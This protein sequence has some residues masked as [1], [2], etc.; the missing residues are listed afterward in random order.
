MTVNEKILEEAKRK[1]KHVVALPIIV[2]DLETAKAISE[3]TWIKTKRGDYVVFLMQI[4]EDEER[5][6][7]LH[8]ANLILYKY[9]L[10]VTGYP[11]LKKEL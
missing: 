11:S 5:N 2:P 6:K 10:R 9:I 1:N 3:F 8:M 4:A 7:E